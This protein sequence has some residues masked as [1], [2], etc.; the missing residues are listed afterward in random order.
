MVSVRSR[1]RALTLTQRSAYLSMCD[2]YFPEGA[3]A[4]MRGVVEE[5]GKEEESNSN[6]NINTNSNDNTSSSS[7]TTTTATSSTTCE[8]EGFP[9][10]DVE[11]LSIDPACLLRYLR[12]RGFDVTAASAMLDATIEWRKEFQ[13]SKLRNEW[14]P[15]IQNECATGKMYVRGFDEQGHALVYMRPKYEN[16][17]VHE[18]NLKHMVFHMEKAVAAMAARNGGEVE[19][20]SIIVDYDGF[21]LMNSPPFKTSM[22][23]LNILQNHYPERLFRAY[24]VRPPWIFNA[25]WKAISPFVDPVTKAKIVMVGSD[26]EEIK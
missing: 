4:W 22:A 3:K 5:I 23:V 14:L 20:L 15:I 2:K 21:S 25:F 9:Y 13:V 16:T 17:S 12:A 18:N 6:N 26:A 7:A 19:K 8:E 1:L 24:L 11:G 10:T